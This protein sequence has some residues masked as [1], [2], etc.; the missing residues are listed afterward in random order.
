MNRKH[1]L[2]GMSSSGKDTIFKKL[3]LKGFTPCISHTTRPMREGEVDGR[4]YFFINDEEFEHMK[5]SNLFVET[6]EYINKKGILWFYGLSKEQ[7]N[8]GDLV[9]LDLNGYKDIVQYV[10][11][12]NIISI[13]INASASARLLRSISRQSE[14]IN[15]E[16]ITCD[17]I[18]LDEI[19][20]RL[21]RDRYDFFGIE[22]EVDYILQNE[23]K[24]DLELN[25]DIIKSLIL[26]VK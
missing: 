6:R 10:G 2:L 1:C 13:Y 17:D 9:I 4:E 15:K 7:C 5:D 22:T 19:Y 24:E 25:I 8:M 26:E 11:K 18:A 14:Q 21:G 16:F 23:T 3:I 12:E 20:R